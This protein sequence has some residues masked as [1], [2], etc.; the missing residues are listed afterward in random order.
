[1]AA[2]RSQPDFTRY[3]DYC[4]VEALEG[5]S[6]SAWLDAVAGMLLSRP[7]L[8]GLTR[9]QLPPM[10]PGPVV[11][12]ADRPFRSLRCYAGSVHAYLM[13][14]ATRGDLPRGL[15]LTGNRATAWLNGQKS[16][17]DARTIAIQLPRRPRSP[18]SLGTKLA[19]WLLSWGSLQ[20][21]R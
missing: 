14:A 3:T 8:A 4:F 10:A 6:D 1:M 12:W 20:Q 18:A 7:P 15:I 19:R 17:F 21:A 5:E 9:A 13:V 16:A 2:I 11:R